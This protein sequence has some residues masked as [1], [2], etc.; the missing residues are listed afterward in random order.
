MSYD[1]LTDTLATYGLSSLLP[2]V[3]EMIED[4]ASDAEITLRLRE[5]P[6]YRERFSAIF[7]REEA[8]LPP[9][10][11]TEVV[12]YEQQLADLRSFYG[13]QDA[14]GFN[15][16]SQAAELLGGNVSL[17]ELQVRLGEMRSLGDRIAADPAQSDI[18]SQMLELGATPFDL[19]E[20]AL[21]PTVKGPEIQRRL[22]AAAIALES[23]RSGFTL[24]RTEAE[25]LAARGVDA[26][27]AGAAFAELNRVGGAFGG[28]PGDD[29]DPIARDM[30]LAAAG[31][32]SEAVRQIQRATQR[33]AAEFGRG[34]S[35]ASGQDGFDGLR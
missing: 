28:G 7:A 3:Q 17:N 35:F 21:D 20:V 5:A 18:V 27:Q 14:P 6:E 10:S 32:D 2:L 19:A 12:A 22:Q 13:A 33:R 9:I 30:Q 25:Q 34:G 8:G 1:I 26:D 16:Q 23:G 4:D 31:G 15:L 11:P 29:R 24:N